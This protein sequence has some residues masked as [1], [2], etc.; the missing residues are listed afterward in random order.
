MGEEVGTAGSVFRLD[1]LAIRV[2]SFDTDS[3]GITL[4]NE[5]HARRGDR[6]VIAARI[7][8]QIKAP[9]FEYQQLGSLTVYQNIS[10]S[11]VNKHQ[12][13]G[14]EVSVSITQ[15]DGLFYWVVSTF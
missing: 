11:E 7:E 5:A 8:Y 1:D 10:S 15:R 6:K 9:R 3:E 2:S 4:L 13:C 12:I 14:Q